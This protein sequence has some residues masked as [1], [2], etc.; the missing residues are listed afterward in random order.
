MLNINWPPQILNELT[1]RNQLSLKD[2]TLQDNS[3]LILLQN[4]LNPQI[5][6]SHDFLSLH[7]CEFVYF[8]TSP[9]VSN[10]NIRPARILRQNGDCKQNYSQNLANYSFV[11]KTIVSQV[12]YS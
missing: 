2:F 1:K 9:T 6:F 8:T 5:T 10:N 7:F 3:L 4:L 12:A 11:A